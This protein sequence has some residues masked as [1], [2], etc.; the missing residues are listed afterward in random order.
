MQTLFQ[1]LFLFI[2]NI[3]FWNSE[4]KRRMMKVTF[5]QSILIRKLIVDIFSNQ[6][7]G[8]YF[9]YALL[10]QLQRKDTN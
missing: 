3:S 6:L 8:L 7:I 2:G 1:G 10:T 4:D 9:P 5:I